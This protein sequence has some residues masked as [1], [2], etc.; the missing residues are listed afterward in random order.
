MNIKINKKINK[1]EK[2]IRDIYFT[3]QF[4][5]SP[6]RRKKTAPTGWEKVCSS[7]VCRSGKGGR[8]FVDFGRE[9]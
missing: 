1:H 5:S 3:S 4:I 9:I 2:T 6:L 7:E 8:G